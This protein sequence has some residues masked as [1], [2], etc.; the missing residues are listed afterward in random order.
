MRVGIV[1]NRNAPAAVLRAVFYFVAWLPRG[2]V[3]VTGDAYGVDFAAYRAAGLYRFRRRRHKADWNELL[4]HAGRE[5]NQRVVDDV[6]RLVAFWNGY[7]D[8][9]RDAVRRAREAGKPVEVIR[10]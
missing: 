6:E 7:S 8:G 1:G 4:G 2:T 9:T 10:W 3:V 5:R